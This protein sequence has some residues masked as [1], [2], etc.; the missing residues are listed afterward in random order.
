M[1][2][3]LNKTWT[4]DGNINISCKQHPRGPRQ[5][6]IR[7]AG[8]RPFGHAMANLYCIY[9]LQEYLYYVSQEYCTQLKLVGC[10]HHWRCRFIVCQESNLDNAQCSN[11]F[12]PYYHWTGVHRDCSLL[13]QHALVILP[14]LL[15]DVVSHRW[16][17]CNSITYLP[18]RKIAFTRPI[19]SGKRASCT[20][21]RV[22]RCLSTSTSL[23]G[24]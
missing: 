19:S 7:N 9:V 11:L 1:V 10:R 14:Q 21:I 13:H 20:C 23:H 2:R 15:C 17:V 8:F 3:T 18:V 4:R 12:T 16:R 6:P 22:W 5:H 24:R